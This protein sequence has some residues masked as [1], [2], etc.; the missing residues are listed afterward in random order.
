[1]GQEIKNSLDA[2]ESKL[3]QIIKPEY[4]RPTLENA[5]LPSH[6]AW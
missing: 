6:V 5:D 1:M 2:E 4:L 3:E